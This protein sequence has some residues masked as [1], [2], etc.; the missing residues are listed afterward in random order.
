LILGL[1]LEG[2]GQLPTCS[3]YVK[4]R[5]LKVST[6]TDGGCF[7]GPAFLAGASESDYDARASGS[8]GIVA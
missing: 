5:R 4:R 1:A 6:L 7:R 2:A 3:D 8:L